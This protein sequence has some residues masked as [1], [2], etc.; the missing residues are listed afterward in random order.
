MWPVT[1]GPEPVRS[2]DAWSS[3]RKTRIFFNKR[4]HLHVQQVI[5][6]GTCGRDCHTR[7]RL[8]AVRV[9]LDGNALAVPRRSLYQGTAFQIVGLTDAGAAASNGVRSDGPGN[10]RGW[11]RR[12]CCAHSR[13]ASQL[14]N[15]QGTSAGSSEVRGR[16]TASSLRFSLPQKTAK[17]TINRLLWPGPNVARR[18]LLV[19]INPSL[20]RETSLLVRLA[21]LHQ[22]LI[23]DLVVEEH[24]PPRCRCS[25]ADLAPDP[26]SQFRRAEL[27]HQISWD[28]L[29]DLTG[30][31]IA[32]CP[33][34]LQ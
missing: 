3:W 14:Q 15:A 20:L 23:A 28:H 31:W 22:H 17:P 12:S 27:S 8:D 11:A 21:P 1:P 24:K 19:R 29:D 33:R 30:R 16:M 34:F 6:Y 18:S 4:S 26:Q 25:P 10:R 9:A 5:G 13:E 32:E 2:P 7:L